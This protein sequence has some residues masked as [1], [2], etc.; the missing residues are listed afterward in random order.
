MS[1]ATPR[2]HVLALIVGAAVVLS[3]GC[4][5]S[6]VV[7]PKPPEKTGAETMPLDVGLY[8]SSEFKS[9][10]VSEFRKGDKW[11][12][13]NLGEVSAAQFRLGL[14]QIFRKVELVD[15]RP[16][17][18]NDSARVLHAVI[19]PAIDK[20]DFEIPITKF[21]VYPARIHYKVTVYDLAGKV[22]FIRTVEGVGD[23]KGSPGFDFTENP[24]KAASK[25]VEDGAGKAF[26]ALMSSD[27][28]KALLK[29]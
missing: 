22:L 28:V 8:L 5:H 7:A 11:N 18:K 12:Y 26:D 25:A 2:L 24:S 13:D 6:I 14:G 3:V 27:E 29:Q 1:R 16:P 20:F 15:E 10:K 17:F 23:F 4:A 19:E 9:Y 21:Q